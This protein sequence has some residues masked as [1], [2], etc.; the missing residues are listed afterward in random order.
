MLSGSH[1]PVEPVSSTIES[2]A[3]WKEDHRCSLSEPIV[4]DPCGGA[5]RGPF[6]PD[7]GIGVTLV[8]AISWS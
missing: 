3:A 8:L 2:I 1:P 6:L 5:L 4:P 7:R